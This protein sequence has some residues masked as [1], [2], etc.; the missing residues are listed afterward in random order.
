MKRAIALM[1]LVGAAGM[2][3]GCIAAAIPI[4]ATGIMGGSEVLGGDEEEQAA[5]AD[6]VVQPVAP[7]A[8]APPAPVV[9][10]AATVATLEAEV[11][12]DAPVALEEED[13]VN[14]PA[15]VLTDY[16]ADPYAALLLSVA[17]KL[18][19]DEADRRSALLANPAS[20]Q[21][22]RRS[23]PA[24]SPNGVIIDVDAADEAAGRAQGSLAEAAKALRD[25]GVTI[26]WLSGRPETDV[27]P[28]RT[29]LVQ[30]GL[31]ADAQDALLM[32]PEG[33]RK[34]ELRQ[35]TGE[36]FCI[37]AIAGDQRSDFD[38]LYDYVRDLDRALALEP[39]IG[40]AW[41]LVPAPL[42]TE[43][44]ANAMGS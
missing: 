26:F 11:E 15:R 16:S 5:A 3:S 35:E 21:P 10:T 28:V 1:S 7:V 29:R 44:I 31:D 38:E 33:K 6:T 43:E 18:S 36:Q 2:L 30:S 8:P 40:E 25:R 23:C 9:S 13:D 14:E 22:E 24:G 12:M 32:L 34:Q 17:A 42:S 41:F 39:L 20:L 37:L 19:E 27:V 4:A